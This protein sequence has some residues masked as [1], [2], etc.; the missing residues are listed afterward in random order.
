MDLAPL[1]E[2]LPFRRISEDEALACLHRAGFRASDAT[3]RASAR[4][5][6]ASMAWHGEVRFHEPAPGHYGPDG[7]SRD[8]ERL[9]VDHAEPTAPAPRQEYVPLVADNPL[10][11]AFLR[12]VVDAITTDLANGPD[13]RFVEAVKQA[14][15]IISE[16]TETSEA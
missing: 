2:S 4:S 3:R 15:Q 14:L 13:S 11:P 10:Y 1:I 12:Q 5:L 8:V 6:F 16:E 7:N 9:K